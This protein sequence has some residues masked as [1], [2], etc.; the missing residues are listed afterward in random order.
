MPA[1]MRGPLHD[2]LVA[3]LADLVARVVRVWLVGIAPTG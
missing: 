1:G 3:A 2:P